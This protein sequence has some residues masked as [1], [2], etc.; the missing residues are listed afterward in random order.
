MFALVHTEVPPFPLRQ[1]HPVGGVSETKVVLF[2]NERASVALSAAL[3]PRLV[4]TTVYV[5][6][7]LVATG[8]GEPESVTAMSALEP[9]LAVSVAVSLSRLASPPPAMFAIFV[10]VAGADCETSA[11]S[12]IDG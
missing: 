5:I 11:L 10:R 1:L 2:G 4:T 7:P 6:V 8:L 12:V 3:G 9:A